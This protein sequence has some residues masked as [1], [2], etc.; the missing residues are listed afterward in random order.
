MDHLGVLHAPA[1]IVGPT[2]E[3]AVHVQHEPGRT[4]SDGMGRGLETRVKHFGQLP[5]VHVG[6]L[7]QQPTV[8]GSVVVRLKQ[9]RPS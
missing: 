5:P 8:T 3:F 4:V 6:I 1:Q 9:R 7:Q 2:K